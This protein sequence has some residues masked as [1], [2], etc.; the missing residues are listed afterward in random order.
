MSL[1]NNKPLEVIVFGNSAVGKTSLLS[2]MYMD[3]EAKGVDRCRDL[4][5]TTLD[6]DSFI[7]LRDKWVELRKNISDNVFTSSLVIPYDGTV[8]DT[9]KWPFAFET[10]K[11]KQQINFVDTKGSLTKDLSQTLRDRINNALLLFCV[12]DASILMERNDV[13]NEDLNC[14]ITIKK[15]LK[16]VLE[17]GDNKQPQSCVFILTKCE[18]YMHTRNGI[19]RLAARFEKIYAPVL[20]YAAEQKFP[21]YYL[22]VQTMGCVEFSRIIPGSNPKKM[23]FKAI[24]DKFQPVDVIFPLAFLLKELLIRLDMAQKSSWPIP[25]LRELLVWLLGMREDYQEYFKD[26]KDKLG[27][28]MDFRGNRN[29]SS[30]HLDSIKDFWEYNQGSS[31]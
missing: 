21:L 31:K 4:K 22:P 17:D 19:E 18:K 6:T 25:G 15:I 11:S 20:Q 10:A 2:S 24:S 12:V 14:P 28:P 8:E 16:D 7:Q 13:D 29:G 30:Q 5:F 9:V 26:L 1:F 23:Q 3:M 27:Q